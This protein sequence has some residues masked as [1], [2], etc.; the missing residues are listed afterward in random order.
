MLTTTPIPSPR[1]LGV[2]HDEWRPNQYKMYQQV[3][4]IDN[5]GGGYVFGELGTGS[6]KS[7]VATA[8]GSQGRVLVNVHTL[9]LLGQYERQYG[10]SVVRGRQE[11][12]CNWEFRRKKWFKKN[13]SY[14]LCSDCTFDPMS[15]CPVA[16]TCEYL[17]AKHRAVNDIRAAC[18]YRYVGVSDAMRKRP[19]NIVFDEAHDAAEELVRFNTLEITYQNMRRLSLP[20]FPINW[21]GPENKGGVLLHKDKGKVLDWIF[22][23]MGRLGK[24]SEQDTPFGSRCR[25]A[26][27]RFDRM[28]ETFMDGEWF[29]RIGDRGIELLALDAARIAQSIFRNKRTKLLM[30]ATLGRPDPLAKA[31]GIK[32]YQFFTYP[33]PVPPEFRMVKDLQ[34]PRMTKRNLTHNADYPY[35]Q[36]QT[37]WRWAKNFPPEWRGVILTT[38]YKKIKALANNIKPMVKGRRLIVQTF[39]EKVGDVVERFI[40]DVKPGDIM[41]GTIQGMGSGL[42]LYGDLARWI[43][44]AGT[45]FKN[46]TDEYE[47]ARRRIFGG[48]KYER[49]VTF[50]A[51]IQACGRVSRAE[52]DEKGNWIPNFAA[53]ADGSCMSKWALREYPKWFRDAII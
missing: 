2:P 43:V 27:R 10:F 26:Y 39:D 30:S 5:A 23:A 13:G 33:H 14:P 24:A 25:R 52:K 48:M 12:P 16:E 11:Y 50:N 18:T 38:S 35:I 31:L 46:P 42:D 22:G 29:L 45:P 53:I 41:V 21:F 28:G 49:W 36:A 15:K 20:Q 19:G 47:K 3:I 17:V 9:S 37:I 8:L 32:D 34:M 7:A 6:G 44:V 51:V 40:T 4:E 1:K